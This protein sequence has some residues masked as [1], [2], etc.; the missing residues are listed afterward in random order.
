MIKLTI[1]Y[2]KAEWY[3]MSLLVRDFKIENVPIIEYSNRGLQA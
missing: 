3:R 1:D 2:L